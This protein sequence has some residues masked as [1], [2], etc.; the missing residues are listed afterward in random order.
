L[1]TVRTGFVHQ[2]A[3]SPSP[4]E[5]KTT[6]GKTT[7]TGQGNFTTAKIT[8]MYTDVTYDQKPSLDIPFAAESFIRLIQLRL[9]LRSTLHE[10]AQWNLRCPGSRALPMQHFKPFFTLFQFSITVAEDTPASCTMALGTRPNSSHDPVP[11]CIPPNLVAVQLSS[12][13]RANDSCHQGDVLKS[14]G[15]TTA[16]L[17]LP[18]PRQIDMFQNCD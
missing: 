18:R 17:L 4:P 5:V 10:A 13:P 9:L 6:R 3:S 1:S 7:K 14:F 12:Q 16:R 11:T 15:G 2:C 8:N